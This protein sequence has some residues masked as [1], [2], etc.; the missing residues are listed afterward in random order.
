[1]LHYIESALSNIEINVAKAAAYI[2]VVPG[3]MK[4]ALGTI[5]T[6]SAIVLTVLS[7]PYAAVT[8]N[9]SLSKR[10]FSHIIHGAA[11][12]SIG[13]LE[14]LPGIGFC[15]YRKRC[16]REE[17]AAW[18]TSAGVETSLEKLRLTASGHHTRLFMSYRD[19][20]YYMSLSC[21]FS[22]KNGDEISTCREE[23]RIRTALNFIY[24]RL[25]KVPSLTSTPWQSWPSSVST[26][27]IKV[28]LNELRDK[29]QAEGG[30]ISADDRDNP[31][32]WLQ[33]AIN[34]VIKKE[35]QA[36]YPPIII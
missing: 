6:I 29:I 21:T 4:V 30:A 13:L 8:G 16:K 17:A 23:D 27:N 28:A 10:F 12:F 33:E 15:L 1:M 34:A 14:A 7:T 3:V 22:I 36:L 25:Y 19:L 9:V 11:N 32:P 31:Y 2:P 24:F 26:G 18:E 5:Q 20:T 35:K